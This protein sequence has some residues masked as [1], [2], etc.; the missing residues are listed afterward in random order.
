MG[1]LKGRV[2]NLAKPEAS[3]VQRTV[4]EEVASW[5]AQYLASAN[6]I[7]VPQSRHE[8]RLQGKGTIGRKVI[9]IDG[10]LKRAVEL[11]VLQNLTEV[12]SYVEEHLTF[13]GK[14]YPSRSNNALLNLHN[15]SFLNWFKKKVTYQL[16]VSP[17]DVSDTL[18]WLAYGCD[19]DITS[20]QGRRG[21]EHDD[22]GFL[23]LV[24]FSR[25]GHHDEP[26]IMASQAKQ[27][28]YMVD[29]SNAQWSV[30]LEGK[31]RILGIDDVVDEQEYDEQFNETPPSPFDI[32]NIL[33]AVANHNEGIFVPIH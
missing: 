10:D 12:H 2:M 5:C 3:I 26:F 9:Q 4:N 16:S 8:G 7:G 27:V 18:R 30:V 25:L 21:V 22:H 24:N 11:F 17:N 15:D 32:P 28:F 33:D 29:P 14:K 1:V 31:R 13:L 20:Y 19:V 23:T 6:K